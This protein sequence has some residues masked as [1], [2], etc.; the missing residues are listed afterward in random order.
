V[1]AAELEPPHVYVLVAALIAL[2]LIRFVAAVD[3][4]RVSQSVLVLVTHHLFTAGALAKLV[5]LVFS[6]V[7][8]ALVAQAQ[9]Y[10]LTIWRVEGIKRPH[11]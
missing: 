4:E 2:P 9:L 3:T 10:V 1:P 8:A 11:W 7:R 6:P 5:R